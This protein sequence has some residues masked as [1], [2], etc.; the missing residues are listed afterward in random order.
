MHDPIPTVP[1]PSGI[2]VPA[3]GQGTWNMGENTARAKDEIAS[4]KTG[5][6]LGMTLLDTAE[7]Y[8]NGGSEEIVGRAIEGRRDE[9]FLV[10][11]VYPHNASRKGTIEAC[12]RSLK[13]MNTDRIDL[14]LLHWRGEYPLAETVAAFESLKATGKIGA[15]GVSN[16][17]VDDMEE[18]FAVPDGGNVAANQVLYNL[19]RRGVEYDVLPWCQERNIPI[20]AYSPIEQG[21][22]LHHPDLI[23]IAK[24]YQA[25]PA[26]V[27]LAFLLER[28]GVIAIPKSSN[29]Q[30]VAENRDAVSLDISDED[31][32]TL[33]AAFPPPSRKK[34]LEML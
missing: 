14:Y 8:A 11:K 22:L 5:L 20:M 24:T 29:T 25:T 34:P 33:D 15:W 13:R 1:L 6:D 7:M 17:D 3:L 23:H 26:Q 31:W 27:A 18:L 9:V 12:E 32:A 2:T 21:R 10:S 19:V 16:F 30:R 28:D 4:L